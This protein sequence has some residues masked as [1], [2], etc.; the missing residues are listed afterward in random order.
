MKPLS[1]NSGRKITEVKI[2]NAAR[3]LF[4][5]KGY[6]ATK[7][8]EIA[9]LA[10]VNLALLNY[11]FRSKERLF[12]IIMMDNY[13]SFLR[14]VTD[15]INDEGTSVEAK[16]SAV[17]SA[18]IDMLTQQPDLPIFMLNEVVSN[19]NQFVKKMKIDKIIKSSHLLKQ[20]REKDSFRKTFSY[21]PIHV[22]I[23]LVSLTIAPFVLAPMIKK[24]TG[25]KPGQFQKLMTERKTL[26]PIWVGD[27][28]K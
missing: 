9:K 20:I 21:D 17:V 14:G 3:E 23:N 2:K 28:Q 24:L 26:I 7:T 6:A 25:T 4:T 11:Y 19:T 16:I 8:R 27:M 18:E 1:P 10:G 13:R 22:L 12:H 5:K 15:I